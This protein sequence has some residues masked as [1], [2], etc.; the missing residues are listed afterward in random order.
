MLSTAEPLFSLIF[1]LAAQKSGKAQK[2]RE[3]GKRSTLM[4][5]ATLAMAML[6]TLATAQV[7]TASFACPRRVVKRAGAAG[8][9]SVLLRAGG[10]AENDPGA[11]GVGV[12]AW[13]RVQSP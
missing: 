1:F 8:R 10:D 13:Q 4:S 12:P 5:V 9:P 2:R 7:T 11:E 3:M 6:L